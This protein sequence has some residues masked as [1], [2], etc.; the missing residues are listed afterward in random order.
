MSKYCTGARGFNHET[1]SC[2]EV[3]DIQY[4]QRSG[5]SRFDADAN[6]MQ[7]VWRNGMPLRAVLLFVAVRSFG[8][9]FYH[10]RHG[11]LIN[12]IAGKKQ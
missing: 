8:W 11:R 9:I 4:A 5:V 12:W 2:C 1:Q 3:H 6:L 10:N 7:C